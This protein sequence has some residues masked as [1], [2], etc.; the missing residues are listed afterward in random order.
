MGFPQRAATV[1]ASILRW[2]EAVGHPVSS[3]AAVEQVLTSGNVLAEDS[4]WDLLEGIGIR[5]SG[6]D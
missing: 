2:A 5:A 3:P 6:R 1:T 4:L